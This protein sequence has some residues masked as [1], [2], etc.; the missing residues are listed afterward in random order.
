MIGTC[1]NLAILTGISGLV[2]IKECLAESFA[3][4]CFEKSD[5]IGGQW[6]YNP[7]PNSGHVHSS[8]YEGCILNSCRDTSSFSDFPMDPARYPDYFGHELHLRYLNE[9]ADHFGLM[10]HIKFQTEVVHC[11]P[12]RNGGWLVKV[13]NAN[14]KTNTLH[15]DALMVATGILSKPRTP[16]FAGRDVYKGKLFHSHFYRT[17]ASFEGKKIAIIGLGS[18]A[19]DIACEV[20]PLAKE[21]HLVTRRGGWVIPRYIF[22]K[23]AEA[24]DGKYARSWHS[25]E[26]INN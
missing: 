2:A 18:S 1:A 16:E 4:Q 6:A 14:G 12:A 10:H 26:W 15:F 20:G 9:Y 3:V 23:P 11:D 19:V 22:G 25:C 17:P 24:W 5:T 8:I 13:R 21:L 7:D